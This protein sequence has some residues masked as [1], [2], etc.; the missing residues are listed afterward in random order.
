MKPVRI[1]R[2]NAVGMDQLV[3]EYIDSMKIASGLNTRRVFAAWDQA[4]GAAQYTIK[5]YFRGGKL[6]ITLNSSVVRNQLSFQKDALVE[7]INLLLD[8]DNL[9]TKE[10]PRVSWVQ[11]II[12]K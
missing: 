12:L 7:K 1:E 4:S 2:K 5:R 11:E 8:R 6:Y 3:K 10:D 9:F